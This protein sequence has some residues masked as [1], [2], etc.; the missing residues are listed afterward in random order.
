MRR[1]NVFFS[2]Q[3]LH[4]NAS[5]VNAIFD[6]L[7]GKSQQQLR[8]ILQ[9]K[10]QDQLQNNSDGQLIIGFDMSQS[11]S[12]SITNRV[13]FNYK[14]SNNQKYYIK[15][16]EWVNSNDNDNDNDNDNN[17]YK[18][19]DYVSLNTPDFRSK[20]IELL[21]KQFSSDFISKFLEIFPESN[22]ETCLLKTESTNTNSTNSSSSIYFSFIRES[23]LSTIWPNI[24]PL[25]QIINPMID[26]NK[27]QSQSQSLSK[28]HNANADKI[29]SWVNLGNSDKSNSNNTPFISLYLV[30]ENKIDNKLYSKK[31]IVMNKMADIHASLKN[32]SEMMRQL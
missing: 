15:A 20:V 18:T 2:Y 4:N 29:V 27:L 16:I 8:K 30:K 23:P 1:Y 12:Q 10:L 5:L 14:D 21:K 28:W 3:Q 32:M 26:K 7:F 25:L 6:T 11:Q 31:N 17:N 9:Q 22:W 19:K 24:Q 13:Y